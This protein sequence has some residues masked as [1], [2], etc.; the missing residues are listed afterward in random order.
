[1]R[2]S[3]AF[4]WAHCLLGLHFALGRRE[5][6]IRH[7]AYWICSVR[8]QIRGEGVAWCGTSEFPNG[9]P[10]APVEMVSVVG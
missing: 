7:Q 8:W 1:M 6:V 2:Y 10:T 9:R 5:L 4:S 3:L